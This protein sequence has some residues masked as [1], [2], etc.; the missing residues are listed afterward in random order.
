[1]SQKWT[2]LQ[3]PDLP[4]DMRDTVPAPRDAALVLPWPI[5]DQ[6]YHFLPEIWVDMEEREVK[7]YAA[8]T[9]WKFSAVCK[10]FRVVALPHLVNH[11]ED[12]GP[13]QL[14]QLLEAFKPETLAMIR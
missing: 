11:L 13:T 14:E 8:T 12:V 10:H 9:R 3:T 1:M 4:I 7:R 5:I 2:V 6:I